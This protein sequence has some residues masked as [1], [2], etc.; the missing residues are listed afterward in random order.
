MQIQ[1]ITTLKKTVKNVQ[2]YSNFTPTQWQ[3]GVTEVEKSKIK[4]NA[5]I[6]NQLSDVKPCQW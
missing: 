3:N 2:H 5:T 4:V 6:L 1:K